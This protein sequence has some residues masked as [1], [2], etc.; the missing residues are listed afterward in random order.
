MEKKSLH[1]YLFWSV[2]VLGLMGCKSQFERIRT[3]GDPQLLYKAG[4]Q[5]YEEE[6]YQK[7]QTLFE[8]IISSYRGRKEAEDLFFK[9]A[10]TYYHL[11]SYILA[12]YYFKNFSQTYTTSDK[13]EE[14]DFMMAYCNYKLS[15]VFRLDQSYTI[16]AIEEFQL[17]V[18]TYPNSER[19]EECN[20]LIDELRAKLEKKAFTESRLYFD[21]RQYQAAMH[22]FENLLRDFPETSRAE[23]VRYFIVR[24]SYLLAENSVLSKQGERYR[25]TIQLAEEF[26]EKYGNSDYRP[27]VEGF[28]K[29][30]SSEQQ[31]I[32]NVRYQ[33]QSAGIRS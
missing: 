5:Y 7:A 1:R 31:T 33:N 2:L 22:T 13:R 12:S 24:S 10:Y 27:E 29:K 30:S 21:L 14:A 18:N 16:Q 19:V 28:L 6:E 11:E 4:M 15:P 26:L 17:F 23:E 9:Y 32:K 3:S 25:R 8:L 20:R